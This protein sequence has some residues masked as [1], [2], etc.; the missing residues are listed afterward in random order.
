M[1]AEELSI[2]A[3]SEQRHLLILE[4]PLNDPWLF[5]FKDGKGIHIEVAALQTVDTLADLLTGHVL[6]LSLILQK[7]IEDGF[8][9]VNQLDL[10]EVTLELI[11]S[12]HWNRGYFL[13]TLGSTASVFKISVII[14]LVEVGEKL[15][16]LLADEE[17]AEDVNLEMGP[18][19][20]ERNHELMV[21]FA[22][23]AL[24]AESL[25]NIFVNEELDVFPHVFVDLYFFLDS[26]LA[27]LCEVVDKSE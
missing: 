17:V 5:I 25:G 15:S 8:K 7:L 12:H 10:L 14:H 2:L 26:G 23:T 16:H 19:F 22:E 11:H 1:V 27:L 9:A 21:V 13:V 20:V 24:S 3:L 6:A 18:N 4:V